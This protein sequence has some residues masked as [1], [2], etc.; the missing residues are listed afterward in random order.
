MENGIA[1]YKI[2]NNKDKTELKTTDGIVPKRLGIALVGGGGASGEAKTDN[3]KNNC[4]NFDTTMPGGG[5]GGGG[6][7]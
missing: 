4:C 2:E 1:Y 6:I 3:W 7:V 5:G